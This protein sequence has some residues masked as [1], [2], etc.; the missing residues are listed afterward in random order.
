LGDENDLAAVTQEQILTEFDPA[1]R[2]AYVI[3]VAQQQPIAVF[4]ADHVAD[5]SPDDGRCPGRDDDR[6]DVQIMLGAGIDGSG[7]QRRLPRQRKADAFQADDRAD[8]D[9]AIGV[10]KILQKVHAGPGCRIRFVSL[11]LVSTVNIIAQ[12]Y[13]VEFARFESR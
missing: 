10:D 9:Q 2:H 11:N 3:A 12:S 7:E 8:R 13:C 4:A 6:D 5:H 1:L